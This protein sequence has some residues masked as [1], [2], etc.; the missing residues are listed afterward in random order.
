MGLALTIGSAGIPAIAN[1]ASA[2]A[3]GPAFPCDPGFYQVISGQLAEFNPAAGTYNKI[4]EDGGNYNAM[5]YRLADG[6]MYAISGKNLYRIDAE[7]TVTNLGQPDMPGG[8]YTGDFGD[9]GLLHVSRGGRDWHKIDVDTLEAT[10]VPELSTYYAV[11]DITNVN[12]KFYGISS[13]GELYIFDPTALTI[14]SGGTVSGLPE[15]HNAYGAAWSTAGG[16]L[17]IGRNS[18]QIFQITGYSKGSPVATQVA[19]SPST[20]SND[21]AACSLA[22]PPEGMED[23]D[24]PEPETEPSTPEAQAAAEAYEEQVKEEEASNPPPES[25][26]TTEAPPE[27]EPGEV[28]ITGDPE[29]TYEADDAN[30]GEGAACEP[31]AEEDMK[32]RPEFDN[33][34][35]VDT[36]TELWASSFDGSPI[37]DFTLLSGSWDMSGGTFNQLNACGYDY[38]AML[39]NHVVK[40]YRWD[41]HF[42]AISGDN[43]GG[44]V[45][46]LSSRHTRSGAMVV[47]LADG[48]ST[49]RWGRYDNAG[50]YQFIDSVPVT[51]PA[52]GENFHLTVDVDGDVAVILVDGVQV[53]KTEVLFQ[54]G[55]VGLMANKTDIAFQKAA[56][57]A[58]PAGFLSDPA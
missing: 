20:N 13:D 57:T 43:Q 9:D 55:F 26:T 1:V 47:D 30:I 8:S 58:M 7:G 53:A 14:S 3:S 10:P 28:V 29:T 12:G 23:V 35:E 27:E 16:N 32:P 4:G 34:I 38:S 22:P 21:G 17:Y 2:Q 11:A 54:G 51:K 25:T 41:A 31:G 18:G 40:S 24:G 36:A 44:L 33:L 48:G 49:L 19:T 50:Y 46:N 45:F 56:L 15:S 42:N 5:G 37:S 6:Y 52:T 39:N